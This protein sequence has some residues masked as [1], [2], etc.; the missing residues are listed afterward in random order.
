M[1]EP[2]WQIGDARLY[3]DSRRLIGPQGT[4]FLRPQQYDVLQ[5]L[6]ENKGHTTKKEILMKSLWNRCET[7]DEHRLQTLISELRHVLGDHYEIKNIF[8]KGYL[9]TGSAERVEP[10]AS[11]A[12][13]AEVTASPEPQKTLWG[14]NNGMPPGICITGS[15]TGEFVPFTELKPE[16]E[17]KLF[18][19]LGEHIPP[20]CTAGLGDWKGRSNWL[21]PIID[22][23]GKKV[24]EVWLGTDADNNWAYDGLVRVGV[25][26]SDDYA[27]VWQVFQ[28]YSDGS[29][30]RIR[31][32]LPRLQRVAVDSSQPPANRRSS[33]TSCS[34]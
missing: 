13:L 5:A 23:D 30:R 18:N 24:G 31:K 27:I 29:Y 14:P 28:R 8:G 32:Q 4:K 19:Q 17:T 34:T 10:A 7:D 11:R 26:L 20:K 33:R 3:E 12:V 21:T 25:A 9:W 6:L 16:M 15:A 2:Y 1:A 22:P